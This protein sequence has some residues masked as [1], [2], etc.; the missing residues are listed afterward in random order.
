MDEDELRAYTGDGDLVLDNNAY[1]LP[2]ANETE[3]ILAAMQ[4]RVGQ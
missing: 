4:A 3:M 1:F 2:H